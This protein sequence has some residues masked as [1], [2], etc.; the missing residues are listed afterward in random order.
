MFGFYKFCLYFYG[1]MSKKVKYERT[2]C[3]YLTPCEIFKGKNVGSIDCLKC[4]FHRSINE[5]PINETNPNPYT[6]I[7]KGIVKCSYDEKSI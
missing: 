1:T 3:E 6:T 4:K 5:K 7:I 2:W